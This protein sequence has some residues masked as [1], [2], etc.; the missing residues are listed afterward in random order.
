[1]PS[2]TAAQRRLLVWAKMTAA[3]KLAD[4]AKEDQR[5]RAAA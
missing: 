2:M 4:M 1:M 3:Q 5:R